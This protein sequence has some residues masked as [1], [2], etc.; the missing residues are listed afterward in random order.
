[1]AETTLRLV[2]HADLKNL[3]PVWTTAYI[4][5]NHGYM[6]YDVLF[7]VNDKLEPQPQ[8]I[9]S[10]TLSP[11]KK[12][13]TFTLREGMRWHDGKPVRAADAV[14][15]ILRW[16]EKDTMG[17]RLKKVIVEFRAMNDRTFVLK[18][19]EPFGLLL[20][21]WSKITSYVPFIMPERMAK[22]DPSK[23]VEEHIGSGPFKFKAE[24]WVP[25]SK[26]VYEKFADY[27]PRPEPASW[28]SGGKVVR[29]DRAEWLY[30]PDPSTAAAALQRGEVDWY[31]VPPVDIVPLLERDPNIQVIVADTLGTVGNMRPNTLHPPFN[32]PKA[33]QALLWMVNQEDYMRAL[34]GDPKYWR[35]C[36][37][38][39]VCGTPLASEEGAEP[40]LKQDLDKARQL[41]KE[42][43]YKGEPVVLMDP[44]DIPVLHAA[45]LVTAQMLRK[46]GVTVEVQAM[47]WSTLTSRRAEKKPPAEGGWNLFHTYTNAA[48]AFTP[49]TNN[50]VDTSCD[51][52]WFG[53]PCDP[54]VAD[55]IDQ[56]ARAGD[57]AHQKAIAVKIQ[58]LMMEVVPYVQ[59]GQW[60]PPTAFRKSLQGVI[61]AP[62]PFLWN[63]SKQ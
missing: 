20:D 24:E 38:Y 31:E 33:R 18:L 41:M 2:P 10:W 49:L 14:A 40:L 47:D 32:N 58:K 28:A 8:M 43:G 55:L 3:D 30:I 37:A 56:Y 44:T 52:A 59:Y 16:N 23:Q 42:A 22:T 6:I 53:W 35:V 63:V 60:T 39:F 29:V 34:I 9:D 62:V 11:D 21:G 5:R 15:S 61:P 50:Q 12:T 26:V 46:I 1:M 45:S 25:G 27:K 57:F 36:A 48:G 54:R 4:T 7:A 13:Y 19:S 51:K 17:Q